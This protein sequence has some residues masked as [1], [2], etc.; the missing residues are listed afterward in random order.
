MWTEVMH[1]ISF[2]VLLV[3]YIVIAVFAFAQYSVACL[4]FPFSFIFWLSITTQ[5][6]TDGATMT[7]THC[8]GSCASVSTRGNE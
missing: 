3:C 6:Q 1:Q 2:I 8:S 4:V 5:H 7:A